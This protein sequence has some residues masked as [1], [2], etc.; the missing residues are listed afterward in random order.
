MLQLRN[1]NFTLYLRPENKSSKCRYVSKGK[2]AKLCLGLP[3]SF[4]YRNIN[5]LSKL[6]YSL[7]NAVVG[8]LVR[9]WQ[10]Q[11]EGISDAGGGLSLLRV[12]GGCGSGLSGKRVHGTQEL[13]CNASGLTEPAEQGAVD[14]GG[15]IPDGV[16]PGEEETRDRLGGDEKP[17]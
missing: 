9:S 5:S 13:I 1:L 3:R 12:A 4:A 14:C 11:G 15:V 2:D 10:E 8:L 17:H 16:L 6:L 7:K